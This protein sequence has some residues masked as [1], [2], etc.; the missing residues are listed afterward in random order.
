MITVLRAVIRLARR[1]LWPQCVH[2]NRASRIV[3]PLVSARP[4]MH[5]GFRTVFVFPFRSHD[6]FCL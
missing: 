1:D 2:L 6:L 3:A 5:H 4:V